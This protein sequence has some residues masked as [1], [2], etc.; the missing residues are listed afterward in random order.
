MRGLIVLLGLG[1]TACGTETESTSERA[2]TPDQSVF[3][4]LTET[5]DR[6]ESVQGTVDQRAEE[7]RRRIEQAE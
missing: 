2:P 1:L 4:P 7:L 6:A 5:L 3:D